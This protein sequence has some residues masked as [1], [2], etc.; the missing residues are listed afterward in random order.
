MLINSLR[1]NRGFHLRTRFYSYA[2]GLMDGRFVTHLY[3]GAPLETVPDSIA[4]TGGVDGHSPAYLAAIPLSDGRVS[5]DMLPQEYPAW[6]TGEHREGALGVVLADG[7]S[8]LRLEYRSHEIR[9]DRLMP[10]GMAML[11]EDHALGDCE[12]LR[13]ELA[14]PRGDLSV[15]LFYLV[16]DEAPALIRW[17]RITNRDD[18]PI[19]LV[20]PA[21]ASIDLPPGRYDAI[22][23]SGTWARERHV[24]RIP[25][26]PGRR[27][28]GSRG[29]SSSHQSSPFV[30]LCDTD[31][32][33]NHGRVWAMTLAYS[34]NFRASLDRD[35]FASCRCA[36]GIGR[37]RAELE[38]GESFDTAGAVMVYS[39]RGFGGM[40]GSFHRFLRDGVVASRWRER[41]RQVIVNSWEAMYFDIDVEKIRTLARGG[42]EIGAELLVLDDGWFSARRDDTTSLGD[43]WPNE[44]LFPGGLRPV[45][46]AVRAE[47]LDFGLWVEP[48]MVS[49]DSELYREHPEWALRIDRREPTRA[50]QQ[51]TLN[52][53]IPA[54]QDFI[55][56][57]VSRIV[58]ETDATYLK[59]DMNRTMTEA[60]ST[61]LSRERQGETMHRYMLG[62]YAV[63]HRITTAHPEVLIEGCAGGGG[64]MDFGLARYS[65]RFW[66]SDQTDAVERLPIQYGTSLLFPP[67]T[68]GA[69][70]SAVPN[71]QVGRIT[72]ARTRV[73]TA[74][75]FSFGFELDPAK[76]S[77]EDRSTFAEGSRRYREIREWVMHGRFIR[78][79]GA[80]ARRHPAQGAT[81]H[82]GLGA[83]HAWMILS[84]DAR[85]AAVFLYKPLAVTEPGPD[86]LRLVGLP[87]DARYRDRSDGTIYDGAWLMDRGLRVPRMVGDYQAFSWL[88]ER[89]D[90]DHDGGSR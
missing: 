67:E 78:L 5:L 48:E 65:P 46:D 37:L 42:R 71:H 19:Y 77:E 89:S 56:N 70:V 49:P 45:A 7:T 50:R 81:F 47:G 84:E 12:T 9:S 23:M 6:G 3:W 13:I 30:A 25:V 58:E 21:S 39:D 36:I 11:R 68:M 80:L 64:R 24:D 41:P 29:G 32:D 18:R 86:H 72:P 61:I 69:H 75:P 17:A 44:E 16:H 83:D 31:T 74:L 90:D 34:G 28:I 82:D 52:L 20:N 22:T 79:R 59:W 76:Q 85:R 51:L 40:S 26:A 8:A 10:A 4:R 38:P 62:L 63:L 66:T 35:P 15:D 14:D 1:D 60:G 43:W 57:T 27:E 55:V 33:E 73:L 88:L 54:V 53:G 2:I 87:G